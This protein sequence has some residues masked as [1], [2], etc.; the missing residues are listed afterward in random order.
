MEERALDDFAAVL[1][2]LLHIESGRA[3]G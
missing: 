3:G 2:P 1:S